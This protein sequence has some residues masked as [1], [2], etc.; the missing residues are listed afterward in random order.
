MAAVLCPRLRRLLLP[1][2]LA[3]LASGNQSEEWRV[4]VLGEGEAWTT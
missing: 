2:F 3:A 1:A 4:S